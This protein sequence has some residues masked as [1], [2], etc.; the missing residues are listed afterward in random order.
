MTWKSYAAVSG[1]TLLVTYLFSAPPTIAPG[2]P[3]AAT[4]AVAGSAP[5][6]VDIQQQAKRLGSRVRAQTEYRPPSRNP[7]RFGGRPVAA[8]PAV[9]A[10]EPTSDAPVVLPVAPPPPPP[11]IRLSGIVTNTVDG[12]PQRSAVLN[13]PDGVVTARAGET[14]GA[15]RIVR[16]D[17]DAVEIVGPDGTTRRLNLR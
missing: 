1:G 8:R 2:R 3:P 9:R 15:Y 16:V 14:A 13:T 4:D 10:P 7:F 11:P 5:A 12:M 17:E 6:T